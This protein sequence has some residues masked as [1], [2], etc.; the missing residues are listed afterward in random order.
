MKGAWRDSYSGGGGGGGIA[1]PRPTPVVKSLLIANFAIFALTY[2]V[3]WFSPGP[4]DGGPPWMFR[5]FGLYPPWW[6]TSPPFLPLWQLVTTGFLHDINGLGHIFWNMVQLYFF[7]TLLEEMIGSRRFAF[8]YVAALIVGSVTQLVAS[9]VEGSTLPAI[10]ASGAVLGVL[11]AAA[12]LRPS[13]SVILLF[14]PITLKWLAIG[15]VAIDAFALL[16]SLK[17]GT[18][19]M[20]AHWAHLGGAAFGFVAAKR[21]WVWL[22]IGERL[23]ARRKQAQAQRARSDEE[24]KDELLAKIHR[25]GMSSLTKREREFL[26]RI[27]QRR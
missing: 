2:L 6:G 4:A 22:D 24:F 17:L 1:L 27:S 25:E 19:T 12:V 7:G 13:T 20:V 14:I 9:E 8:V 3:S 23:A 16:N 26:R 10:G 18:G 5:A 11:V 21:G 15:I